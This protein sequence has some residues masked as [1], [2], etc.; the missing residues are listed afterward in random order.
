MISRIQAALQQLGR[1]PLIAAAALHCLPLFAAATFFTRGLFGEAAQQTWFLDLRWLVVL[2]ACSWGIGYLPIQRWGRAAAVFATGIVGNLLLANSTLAAWSVAP[3]GTGD[4]TLDRA[5]LVW[6]CIIV[7]GVA[8]LLLDTWW[9]Q[10]S[11]RS[12]TAHR[13]TGPAAI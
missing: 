6:G 3:D 10:R 2:S 11:E 8:A 13:V 12:T 1:V 4:T 9:L 7:T 5:S